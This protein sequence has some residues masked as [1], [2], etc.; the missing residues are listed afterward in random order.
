M[1]LPSAIFHLNLSL[2][3][4]INNVMSFSTGHKP[5]NNYLLYNVHSN[6]NKTNK[7]NLAL[8]PTHSNKVDFKKIYPNQAKAFSLSY[9]P[10]YMFPSL[11]SFRALAQLR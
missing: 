10:T 8:L 5:A 6:L 3:K 7:T 1:I 9:G 11:F 2:P 4:Q